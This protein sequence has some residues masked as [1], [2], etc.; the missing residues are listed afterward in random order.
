MRAKRVLIVA[1]AVVAD[2]PAGV[3]EVVRRQVLDADEVRVIGPTLTTKLQSWFSDID[4]AASKA[5]ERVRAIV[6]SIAAAGQDATAGGVG[7]ERPLQAIEDALAAF[8]ADALILAV[9][10]PDAENWRERGLGDRV[11]ER[12]QVPVTEMVIDSAGRV[13]EVETDVRSLDG[14]EGQDAN[15]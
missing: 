5:D 10:T 14:P 9:H 8:P 1:N 15:Q 3:P 11:R 13:V 2:R 12:F 6:E 7:D 4:A